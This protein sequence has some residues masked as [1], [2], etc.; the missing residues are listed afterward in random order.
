MINTVTVIGSINVDNILH[1]QAL[2]KPGE[3]IAMSGYSTAG[4]GK[5]ANQA[6]AAARSGAKTAFIGAVGND[7]NGEYMKTQL[8]ENGIN[9][10]AVKTTSEAATGQAYILLQSSGQNSIIIDHGANAQVTVADVDAVAAAIQSSTFLVTEFETPLPADEEAFQIARAAGVKTIL[11]P[12]PAVAQIPESLL[13]LTDII[14]PNETE[15]QAI[16]GISVDDEPSLKASAEYYHKLGV[17]TVIITLGDRGAYVA[18]G[19][20]SELVP[21]YKVQAVDTTAAGDT[22]IGALAAEL[23]PDGS[24]LL[25]AV[26]YASRAASLTVQ[27][28]GAF[29][30]IPL[31]KSV[32]LAQKE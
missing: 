12:A 18:S 1:I 5:G 11:N 6:I 2:P 7:A 20:I 3:T 27:K 10:Q 4:G 24:N 8:L 31:R 28:L 13:R 21:A 29:P 14:V 22:F 25:A 16:T 9:V 30:S 17:E 23:R 26:Q 19:N 32:L 15:S